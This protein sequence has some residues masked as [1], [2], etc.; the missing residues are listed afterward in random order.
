M[1]KLLFIQLAL[2][3]F[4]IDLAV[5]Q[6]AEQHPELE[7]GKDI[8]G[9]R[10]RLERLHN[11]GTAG[12]RLKGHMPAIAGVSGLVTG[13]CAAYFL[14]L[15]WKEGRTLEKTGFAFLVGGAL[16]NLYERCKNGYVVDY[17][18]V[19]FFPYVF[20]FADCCITVGAVCFVVHYLFLGE[21]RERKKRP[22][23]QHAETDTR[24]KP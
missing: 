13:G 20:N 24:E 15:L 22:P 14:R 21:H 7:K 6:E 18:H 10:V 16:S 12:G 4:Q 19:L 23:L 1:K 3:I 11:H 2:G 17:I 5:R 9:G 8:C